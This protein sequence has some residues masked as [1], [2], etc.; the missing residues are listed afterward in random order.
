MSHPAAVPLFTSNG[1][2]DFD[3]PTPP[4]SDLPEDRA[5]P[6]H[7]SVA[8]SG[9]GSSS[10]SGRIDNQKANHDAMELDEELLIMAAEAEA[11]SRGWAG[12]PPPE[13]DMEEEPDWE[14]EERLMRELET[15]GGGE[16]PRD[17]TYSATSVVGTGKTV[18]EQ[19]FIPTDIFDFEEQEQEPIAGSC[20]SLH[21]LEPRWPNA[22]C[23]ST[24]ARAP[25]TPPP[26]DI[27]LVFASAH[28]VPECSLPPLH[29]ETSSGRI[30][31]FK[32]R[33]KPTPAPLIVGPLS[34]LS[35]RQYAAIVSLT[36]Q[37]ERFGRGGQLGMPLHRLLAEVEELR[38]RQ[39]ALE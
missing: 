18:Q 15:E 26:E 1:L 16:P 17:A 10:K 20:K 2:L 9:P 23:S 21:P 24:S 22:D 37:T 25:L 5:K 27:P 11:R 28:P 13:M 36:I 14:E 32:R 31:S 4:L 3:L 7:P 19:T 39:K 33:F 30:V 34:P 6:A 38:G 8:G 12:S 35:C 29:A